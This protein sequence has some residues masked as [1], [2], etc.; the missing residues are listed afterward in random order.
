LT[1]VSSGVA[2]GSFQF[3]LAG[4]NPFR[5]YTTLSYSL[6]EAAPV[7]VAVYNLA[8][9]LVRTLVDGVQPAG[10]HQLS[11]ARE[12]RASGALAP[13]MYFVRITAGRWTASRSVIALP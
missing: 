5:D 4:G 7:R 6:P 11:L 13:G 8:G 2:A 1:S 12:D 10:S 9:A 3:A